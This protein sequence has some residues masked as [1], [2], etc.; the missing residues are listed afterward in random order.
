LIGNKTKLLGAIQS[1]LE[2][3]GVEGGTFL[4]VF[5]GTASVGRHFR[6][7]G[8]RVHTNDLL[9]GSYVRQRAYIQTGRPPRLTRVRDARDVRRFLRSRAGRLAVEA[10]GPAP[11]GS[12]GLL[13]V[14]AYLN[15]LDPAPGLFAR[16]YS[17]GG[18]EGRLFFSEANGGRIDAVHDQLDRWRRDGRLSETDF[19]VLLTALLE[20]ADRVANISG[21]YGAFLKK[22]QGSAR[23]P[24]TLRLLELDTQGPAGRA[25]RQDA[26]ELVRRVRADVLYLDPPYNQ[27]Q[28]AKNYH[29]IEVLAELHTVEDR[30]A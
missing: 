16:H 22:L 29:V 15:G 13:E 23:E 18:S 21:T 1:F 19:Y 25:H 17:E 4:D 28:Y 20:A 14:I 2:R 27:R 9:M 30:R 7:L 26:N 12:G 5:A 3:R 24:L 11:K 6:R 10:M 8:Y